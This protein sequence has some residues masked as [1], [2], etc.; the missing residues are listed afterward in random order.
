MSSYLGGQNVSLEIRARGLGVPVSLIMASALHRTDEW[1]PRT[2]YGC[3]SCGDWVR[4]TSGAALVL[5]GARS[6]CATIGSTNCVD[7]HSV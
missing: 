4:R 2:D 7:V 1:V 3:G 6:A 5:T